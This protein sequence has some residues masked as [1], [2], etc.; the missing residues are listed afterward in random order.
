MLTLKQRLKPVRAF[1]RTV[2][3]K[4]LQLWRAGLLPS[5]AHGSSVSGIS[6]KELEV[7]RSVTAEMAGYPKRGASSTL[8]L[9]TQRDPGYDPL[10]DATIG[11]A[12]S[13]H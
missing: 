8:Y 2:G 5:V 9:A 4:V 12:F 7:M 10:F 6:D 11:P 1:R 13:Y 3:T